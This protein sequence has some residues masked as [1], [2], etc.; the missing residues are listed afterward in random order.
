VSDFGSALETTLASGRYRGRCLADLAFGD[1]TERRYL[2]WLRRC[3]PDP[4]LR[5]AAALVVDAVNER[6]FFD[7][8]AGVLLLRAH[9]LASGAA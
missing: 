6:L 4:E 5:R 8:V 9:E 3:S 7:D 2:D 1:E